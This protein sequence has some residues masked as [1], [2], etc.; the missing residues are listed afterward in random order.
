MVVEPQLAEAA[1]GLAAANVLGAVEEDGCILSWL[2]AEQ[3]EDVGVEIDFGVDGGFE[4]LCDVCDLG[5]EGDT[6]VLEAGGVF[7]VL[8]LEGL[9]PHLADNHGGVELGARNGGGGWGGRGDPMHFKVFKEP[10]PVAA[11]RGE[12]VDVVVVREE[13]ADG[14]AYHDPGG[15][16][17][18]VVLGAEVEVFFE[19]GCVHG[20]EGLDDGL[21]AVHDWLKRSATDLELT[22]SALGPTFAGGCFVSK[23]Q[24]G[25]QT[26]KV[27]EDHWS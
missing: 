3:A 21:A 14:V 26:L 5:V 10:G 22:T 15:V 7:G 9:V 20:V 27:L 24:K 6:R 19:L 16:I 18:G 11:G 23:V 17:V 4:G 13:A 1:G 2:A 25:L 8:G 12:D